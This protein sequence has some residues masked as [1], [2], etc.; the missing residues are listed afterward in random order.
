MFPD[1]I[2]RRWPFPARVVDLAI[3]RHPYVVPE[4]HHIRF[5]CNFVTNLTY[6]IRHV[7]SAIFVAGPK[8][9]RLLVLQWRGRFAYSPPRA[10]STDKCRRQK[11]SDVCT[12]TVLADGKQWGIL[13]LRTFYSRKRLSKFP[14]CQAEKKNPRITQ[15]VVR[16]VGKFDLNGIDF[17]H[18]DVI[19]NVTIVETWKYWHDIYKRI[20]H[21][22]RF[23]CRL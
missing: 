19:S 9:V 4:F 22:V 16:H 21:D 10:Y 13:F 1:G 3:C 7:Q 8:R 12:R 2:A 14:L 18:V 20:S 15:S 5:M 23:S 6:R 11:Y 17:R